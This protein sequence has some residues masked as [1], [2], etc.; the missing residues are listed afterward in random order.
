MSGEYCS[1]TFLGSPHGEMPKSI[2]FS[3]VF[4]LKVLTFVLLELKKVASA[5]VARIKTSD[6]IMNI[7]LLTCGTESSSPKEKNPL[8]FLDDIGNTVAAV[9]SVGV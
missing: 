2:V 3:S 6:R 8:V 7:V 9:G 5:I 1:F 4:I